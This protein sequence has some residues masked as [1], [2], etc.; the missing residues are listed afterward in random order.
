M[1]AP[2]MEYDQIQQAGYPGAAYPGAGY[3]PGQGAPP[4]YPG[5]PGSGYPPGQGA[6]GSG[7]PPG[8][9]VPGS[10]YPPGQGAPPGYTV[11]DDP[12]S[13]YPPGQ[14]APSSGG[15]PGSG[16][17]P[18]QSPGQPTQTPV[19]NVTQVV[20]YVPAAS[21]SFG[22]RPVSM[23]CPHCQKNITTRTDSEASALA[24]IIGGVLCLLALWPCACIPCCIDSLQQ[25][26][27]SC[28]NCNNTLG[29]YKGGL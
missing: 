11:F 27:H 14:M 8:Q 18:S 21:S 17:P 1:S 29:I 10:G 15:Y 7:Y 3:P 26:T 23:V 4:G 20:Q 9:G 19:Q 28:P 16:Y 25:V 5:V 6:P 22:I 2:P 13:G 12:S 24:W